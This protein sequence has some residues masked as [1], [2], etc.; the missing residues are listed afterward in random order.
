MTWLRY[1]WLPLTV[2]VAA[3]GLLVGSIAW[4][5]GAGWM[6]TVMGTG[7][8][9]GPGMGGMAIAGD[10]Q[11]RDLDDAER[12][13]ARLADR[14]GLS[15]GEVMQFDNGFYAELAEPSGNLATEVLID[16]R[17]GA[18]QVEFGP[19][20]V[21]NASYGMHPD[22]AGTQ[23]V[24]SEQAQVIADRWLQSNRSGERAGDA[25]AFP[26]YFTLHT[27]RGDQLVGMLS[28][29]AATGAVW[30]HTWHGEFIDMQDHDTE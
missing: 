8:M 28:V 12:A 14:W 16:P 13:A 9:M 3:V 21:W 27:L 6:P 17:S 11:V 20:M 24:S 10:G 23:T 5:A 15:V 1:R 2:L 4:V 26:G 19:A 29:N 30:Y 7:G 18:V 25:D 22:G